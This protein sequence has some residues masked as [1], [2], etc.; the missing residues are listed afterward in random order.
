M[1]GDLLVEDGVVVLAII[2]E[3]EPM[4]EQLEDL[5]PR[6]ITPEQIESRLALERLDELRESGSELTAS[7]VEICTESARYITSPA[8]ASRVLRGSIERTFG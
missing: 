3:L 2:G 4:R 8:D 7:I 6:E 1:L 5:P